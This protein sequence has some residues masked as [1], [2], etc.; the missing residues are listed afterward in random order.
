M[1]T[2]NVAATHRV[3]ADFVPGSFSHQTLAAV[4]G[5]SFV[6]ETMSARNDLAEPLC[7]TAR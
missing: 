5:R 7:G 1:F 3:N 2:D 4:P 6:L